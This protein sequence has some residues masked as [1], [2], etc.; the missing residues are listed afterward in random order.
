MIRNRKLLKAIGVFLL[1]QFTLQTFLPA[2]SY[3][4]TSGPSQPEFS[5]FEPVATT[6]MVDVFSGDFTYNLPVIEIPGPQ[7][8]S[9]P[10]SLSYHSGVTPEEE[11]SW[12]GYGWTLNPGAI[13]RMTRGLPDDYKGD[14]VKFR[15]KAP[16]NW[17]ASVSGS[18]GFGE[19]FGTDLNKILPGTNG[20]ATV[21]IRYNNYRGFGTSVGLGV[22]LGKGLISMGYTVTDGEGSFSLTANPYAILSWGE[23]EVVHVNEQRYDQLKNKQAAKGGYKKDGALNVKSSSYGLFSYTNSTKT[24]IVH[25]FNGKSFN[26]SVGA[27]LNPAV[28]P[29]GATVNILGSY[30]Y[31]EN[32]EEDDVVSFGYM[33]SGEPE[34]ALNKYGSTE[35]GT[36]MDYH[37]EKEKD[38]NPRD[39]FL[40][41][42]FN[43]ADN[44]IVTGE[45]IGGGFRMYNKTL[46]HFGPRK[47]NSHVDI[48]NIGGEV[49]A[50]WTFGPG[51]DLGKGATDLDAGDWKRL[52]DFRRVGAGSGD[53]VVDEPVFFR[54]NNDLGGEWGSAHDDKPFQAGFSDK[55]PTLP[56]AAFSTNVNDE[57]SGRSSYIGYHTNSQMLSGSEPSLEAFSRIKYYNDHSERSLPGRADLIGEIMVVNE[58]GTQY[59]YGLPVYAKNEKSLS[60]SAKGL[61]PQ[62]NYIAFTSSPNQDVYVGEEKSKEYASAYLL[63]EILTPSYVDIPVFNS[64]GELGASMDDL[65]GYT[66]LNYQKKTTPS[67]WYVWRNPYRGL[68]YSRNQQSDPQD[69]V[70]SYSEGEKEIYYVSTIETKTHVA[71]FV[72]A[73]RSDA[74]E[75]RANEF[76]NNNGFGTTMSDK[77]VRIELYAI[78]DFKRD[79]YGNLYRTPSGSF[80][81]NPELRTDVTVKPIK[82]V[83][84]EYS[85]DLFSD[86]ISGLPN[87]QD[88][89][90]G[91]VAGKLTL[92][93]VYFEYN[94]ISKAKIS[95]YEFEYKYPS[96]SSY[97]SKYRT[98]G[99][100]NVSV[101]FA[102]LTVADQN[103]I[104][105]YFLTDAW[106]NYQKDG[107]NRF[108]NNQS[109]VDQ[110]KQ[111]NKSGFDPAAWQLKVIKLPSGGEIHVQY[112]QDDYSYV[113]DQE[114]HVM[115]TLKEDPQE[116]L[117]DDL[118][119]PP[120]YTYSVD[121]TSIGL[122]S[123]NI[124][125]MNQLKKMF[126][127]RYVDQKKKIYFKILYSLVGDNPANLQTC[128][129][130]YLTGYASV[131]GSELDL[132]NAV[133]KI[134]LVRQSANKLPREV[135]LEYV[136]TQRLGN[137]DQF[138]DCT[139]AG[140]NNPNS[141]KELVN[142]LY[143]LRERIRAPK[144]EFGLNPDA[145]DMCR[146][147]DK[148][149]SY[150]RIPTP[151]AKKGGG[152][153]VKRLMMFDQGL[154]SP[155]LYGS[156]YIYQNKEGGRTISSGVATN[157]PQTIR[158]ENILTDFVARKGQNLWSKV[159]AG[160]D[161]DQAEGPVGESILPGPSVG[162]S[163]VTVKNIHS[164]KSNPGYTVNEFYTAKDYPVKL[165]HPDKSGTMTSIRKKD[166]TPEIIPLP[167][168]SKVKNR[169]RA[170]QGFSYVLNSMHGQAR[171]IASYTGPYSDVVDQAMAVQTSFV[172]YE[173]YQP[174]EK[175]PM[176]SSLLGGVSMRNPGREVDITYAQR[177]VTESSNDVNV[178]VDLQATIIPLAFIVLVIPFPTAVPFF[179][180]VEGELNTHTTTKVV[181][182]PAILKKTEIFENGIT[183]TQENLAFDQNTGRPVS[184]R[185]T[186]EFKGGYMQQSIPA[187]W[188]YQAMAGKWKTENR[189]LAG[190]FTV[191]S[192]Y[193]SLTAGGCS[194]TNFTAGDRIR[195]GSATSTAFYYVM[196][197]DWLN[198]KIRVEKA[199]GATDATGTYTE[200]TIV[201][202]GRTNQ[203]ADQAG[204]ITAHN[205]NKESLS[206]LL[207]DPGTRYAVG[208]AGP[209]DFLTDF[210]N[211]KP[212]GGS[213]TFELPGVYAN[214]NMSAFASL[215]SACNADLTNVSIKQLEYRYTQI[216][217]QISIELMS[218]DINC[219]GTWMT[220]SA[221]GW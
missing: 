1:L 17:T 196:E 114:A 34:A 213:G 149:H 102:S 97:P 110:T 192:G 63:T 138:S 119:S 52:S 157:E 116:D 78:E 124:A 55:M 151:L 191:N 179:S 197:L 62:N 6:N 128:N 147:V 215:L 76:V 54:F 49:G 121:L 16:R 26:V 22:T 73:P 117:L 3:A 64:K 212:T 50:G 180:S 89:S 13:N 198:N 94:G 218:F 150:F 61:T 188:E 115:A 58:T 156:E 185:S 211:M 68:L 221:V 67:D 9:Y 81:G 38:F 103:P 217:S 167:F 161:K 79:A 135:C 201:N 65:G 186:D 15:N 208:T 210:N 142:N 48:F 91:G 80:A 24:N 28:V 158:E 152:L 57:R 200:L 31:Q 195:L 134:K 27:E 175:I 193:I 190:S 170:T 216:G 33:Y 111:S 136:K 154:D 182:Y 99:V 129:A 93:R 166:D 18:L 112:E 39:V 83:Y 202:S 88:I 4:L 95:P 32:K 35:K 105:S 20:S 159:I 21:G 171:S 71:L 51:A 153:R 42:P 174:G 106:G 204:S 37:V 172:K 187:S 214:M 5:S 44:F 29:A 107:A 189:R 12:V 155:V 122:N 25:E 194:L 47:V 77:L 176:V 130:E 162:Y 45:G 137:I 43:D 8:S 10:L 183:H 84:F 19:V 123:S 178:E 46:G 146:R 98:N 144:Y 165:A 53:Q 125:E 40:G 82:T 207:I 160:K 75:A 41:V 181:R 74:R 118:S 109:W 72:T 206:P 104:Y 173:Y 60:F 92:K 69:D 86:G 141:S 14:I 169:T 148:D 7:G 30:T 87:A 90:G 131:Y 59:N 164:G 209:N 108:N 168:Y 66:R 145:P 100:D 85:N 143:A 70:G 101:D 127:K 184:V 139:S 220:I 133:L 120:Y 113:Q 199:S 126:D 219:S 56:S 2:I 140:L 205:E 36:L 163:R 132:P 177:R 96:Y 203:L 11:A 23:K